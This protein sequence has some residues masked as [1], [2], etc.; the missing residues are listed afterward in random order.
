MQLFEISNEAIDHLKKV[1]GL[2]ETKEAKIQCIVNGA[3]CE[4]KFQTF[5]GLRKHIIK[6]Q[7]EYSKNNNDIKT[8]SSV[9][10]ETNHFDQL[11]E[12]SFTFEHAFNFSQSAEESFCVEKTIEHKSQKTNNALA[13]EK[14]SMFLKQ[15]IDSIICLNLSQK[16]QMIYSN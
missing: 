7:E 10:N 2:K 9:R 15:F 8:N 16:K 4:K 12:L 5:S 14:A 1:H 6:C 3:K 11:N 13:T